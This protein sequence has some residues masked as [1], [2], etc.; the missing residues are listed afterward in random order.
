M[1]YYYIPSPLYH[2]ATARMEGWWVEREDDEFMEHQVRHDVQIV[3]LRCC[4]RAT[5][6]RPAITHAMHAHVAPEKPLMAAR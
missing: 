6:H 2:T 3:E 5:Q 4:R 1:Y